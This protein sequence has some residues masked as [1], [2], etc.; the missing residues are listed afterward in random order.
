MG[1]TMNLM[2]A[3]CLGFGGAL[4]TA[5]LIGFGIGMAYPLLGGPSGLYAAE[6]GGVVI[7]LAVFYFLARL[8]SRRHR[9]RDSVYAERLA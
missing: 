9:S 4:L 6:L 5:I 8:L 3:I 1:A 7:S 2:P